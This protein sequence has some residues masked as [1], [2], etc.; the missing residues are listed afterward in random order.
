MQDHPTNHTPN[1]TE[2]HAA[3]S[4]NSYVRDPEFR[5]QLLE[6]IFE[7]SKEWIAV[8]DTDMTLLSINKSAAMAFDMAPEDMIGKT[9][10]QMFP[11]ATG[12]QSEADLKRALAGEEVR[13][14][15][16]YSH[17][18]KRWLQN[19]IL[20][21]RDS[22]GTVYAAL[23]VANDITDL[24]HANE[25]QQKSRQHFEELFMISPVAKTLSKVSDGTIINVNPAWERM[26]GYRK[27]DVI[28]KNAEAL[29]LVDQAERSKKVD[30][31]NSN[32]GSAH[33]F[34]MTF[35]PANGQPLIAFTSVVT[36]DYNG[37]PC[38]L[39]AY[40]DI[41]KRK[42][43]EEQLRQAATDLSALSKTL[44]QRNADLERANKELESFNY[45]AS[46][47]LQEPL[48]KIRTFISMMQPALD[49]KAAMTL[50]MDK[51]NHAAVRM[52]QLIENVLEYA[53]LSQ[54]MWSFRPTDLNY[55]L[56][57]VKGDYELLIADKQAVIQ[58]DKLPVIDAIALQMHQL[59]SNLISNALKYSSRTPQINITSRITAKH[60]VSHFADSTSDQQ[61]V[62]LKFADNGIGFDPRYKEE[63][64][65]LFQRLH[66]KQEY[67]GTGVGLSIVKKI[68][69]Q[70]QG[71]ITAESE[72]AKGTTFT[73][74]LPLIQHGGI[75]P[76]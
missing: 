39:G 69:G 37:V 46:H 6:S 73:I 64:F 13:N 59:F 62:E 8:Y 76:A 55:V 65:K 15:N 25:E 58:S 11:N 57:N 4:G 52:S 50:Y 27:E 54:T 12:T 22:A 51:I 35:K 26:F 72:Q 56:D 70:H 30:L 16:F 28:G 47:D 74:W 21:L 43:D 5:N 45:I 44:E 9:L 18:S 38:F 10:Y 32:G 66:G 2:S 7:N 48:R 23:A 31:V 14:T 19:Y 41:T 3:H 20:P 34:E 42:I 75:Q 61:M 49:D 40:V 29:G 63:I 60:Q 68:V 53:R 33:G 67:G 17:I 36:M 24:V 1:Q 71:Y